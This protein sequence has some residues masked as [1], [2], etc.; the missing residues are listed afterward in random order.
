[1]RLGLVRIISGLGGDLR[2]RSLLDRVAAEVD[3]VSDD[4]AACLF[5]VDGSADVEMVRSEELEIRRE[6]L[7]RTVVESFLAA[8]G[9]GPDEAERLAPLV[10]ETVDRF[11][12][13]VVRVTIAPDGLSSEVLPAN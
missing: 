3:G 6:D 11:G 13:A 7:G 12:R 8:C 4:M 9:L 5:R 10:R 1:G 2:A